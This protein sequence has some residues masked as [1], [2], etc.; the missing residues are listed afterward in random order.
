LYRWAEERVSGVGAPDRVKISDLVEEANQEFATDADW[1]AQFV[2]EALNDMVR[3][4]IR[5]AVAS[6]RGQY[7]KYVFRDTVMGV[8]AYAEQTTQESATLRM[9]L[10]SKWGSWMEFNGRQHVR[11]LDMTR[12][13]LIA[14]AEERERRAHRELEIAALWREMAAAM[15][16]DSVTVRDTFNVA[17]IE[18]LS[19]DIKVAR[20]TF[21]DAT[22]TPAGDQPQDD[23]TDTDDAEDDAPPDGEPEP[24]A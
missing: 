6:T 8:R 23:D 22:T 16:D 13:D 7:K 15:P 10:M 3:S 2:Q 21:D 1:V 20:G 9:K 4:V 19:V 12:K 24:K 18:A 11:L 14:A 5:Q 17:E